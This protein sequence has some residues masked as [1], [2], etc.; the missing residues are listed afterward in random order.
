MSALARRSVIQPLELF[1][2]LQDLCRKQVPA[3]DTLG[4]EVLAYERPVFIPLCEPNDVSLKEGIAGCD[5]KENNL[6][7]PRDTHLCRHNSLRKK[8]YLVPV[9]NQ[10]EG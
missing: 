6:D 3:S 4:M 10:I 2:D 5:S 8:K 9:E 1:S 7:Q